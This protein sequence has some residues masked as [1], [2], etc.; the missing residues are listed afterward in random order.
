MRL[1]NI[2][3]YETLR[4]LGGRRVCRLQIQKVPGAVTTNHSGRRPK[5][6]SRADEFRQ[7]LSAWKRT[8][9]SSRPSLRAFSRELGTS[10]QLLSFYL[11]QWDKWRAKEYRRKADDIRARAEAQNRDL[12][13]WEES[14]VA[15][16]RRA[17]FRC[18]LDSALKDVM[19]RWLKELREEAKRGKLSKGQLRVAK[20]L[21]SRGY[22]NEIRE[23]LASSG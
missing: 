13:Q 23:I 22:R 21:A 19:P 3:S 10:H 7:R 15:A 14:Q 5:R 20:I 16:Y 4:R 12:S 2:W 6:E 8:P 1:F 18:L 11:K 9:E 17:S